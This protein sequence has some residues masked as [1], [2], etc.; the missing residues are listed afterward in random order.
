VE[1]GTPSRQRQF[2]REYGRA[3]DRHL[4]AIEQVVVP[5]L[6]QR[7]VGH[8]LLAALAA[9][10]SLCPGLADAMACA[11]EPSAASVPLGALVA[12]ATERLQRQAAALI[13]LVRERLGADEVFAL[14]RRLHDHLG[15]ATADPAPAARASTG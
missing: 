6:E 2:L 3:L 4:G 5:A 15:A 7:G 11:A 8:D 14:G 13:P 9:R 12:D 1:A 10:E